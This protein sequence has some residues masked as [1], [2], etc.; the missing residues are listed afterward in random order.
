MPYST[1]YVG[2]MLIVGE[3]RGGIANRVKLVRHGVGTVH[4]LQEVGKMSVVAKCDESYLVV[5][6]VEHYDVLIEDVEHVRCIV[7]LH[8]GVLD[9][10]ILKVANGIERGVAIQSAVLLVLPRDA[11]AGNEVVDGVIHAVVVG[12]RVSLL[13]PIRESQ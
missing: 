10:N 2:L 9:G 6:M 11:E 8:G 7:S 13:L 1:T 3:R 5:E 4:H 12:Y